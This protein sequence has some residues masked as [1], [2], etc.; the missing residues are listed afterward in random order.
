ME[1]VYKWKKWE[2]KEREA[3]KRLWRTQN[4]WFP[5]ILLNPLF[6]CLKTHTSNFNLSP[7]SN[8]K[9]LHNILRFSRYIHLLLLPFLHISNLVSSFFVILHF[10]IDSIACTVVWYWLLFEFRWCFFFVLQIFLDYRFVIQSVSYKFHGRGGIE[11]LQ[12]V[13][14]AAE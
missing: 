14:A 13:V 6:L 7:N 8:S 4:A 3:I 12:K 11:E 1:D 5:V 2:R 10:E 9:F